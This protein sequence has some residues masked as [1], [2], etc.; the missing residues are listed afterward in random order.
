MKFKLIAFILFT[1]NHLL[2]QSFEGTL[3]YAIDIEVSESLEKMGLTKDLMINKMKEDG[4]WSD[5]IKTS[6]KQGNY[7]SSLN[8]N[9]KRYSIYNADSNK[10]YV[11]Q[12]LEGESICTVTDA[13]IDLESTVTNKLP[14]ITK[15]DTIVTINGIECNIVRVKWDN[16]NYDYY[17]NSEL[18]V[19]ASL[20]SK[21][22]YD[23]WAEFLKI[24]N[25]LPVKI[26]KNIPGTF[27]ITFS[28]TNSKYEKVDDSLFNVPQLL[29]DE[30]LDLLKTANKKTMRVKQ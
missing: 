27:I 29:Y 15:L 8:N 21:H 6:Y 20:F 23:G 22:R 24:S 18:K 13:S 12:D 26:V 17:Y 3:T 25:A 30:D 5:T 9:S 19:E 2:S 11:I 16:E 14:S 1:T 4:D 10:I 28:L 7:Y